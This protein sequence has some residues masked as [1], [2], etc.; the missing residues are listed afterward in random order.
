MNHGISIGSIFS[1][2][3]GLE[4]GLELANLGVTEWQ[5]E[6]EKY[7]REVLRRHWPK[8][9]QFV[10]VREVGRKNLS[11]V[12]I[13]CGGF[14]CQ[15]FSSSGKR[16]GFCDPRSALWAEQV[17]IIREMSPGAV[18]VENVAEM[19][20]VQGEQRVANDLRKL[21]YIV[22]RPVII[23]AATL[24]APHA[25]LRVFMLAFKP[26]HAITVGPEPKAFSFDYP[27]FRGQAPKPGE[28]PRTLKK[29]TRYPGTYKR[30]RLLA[31]GN[32]VMPAMGYVVGL[33]LRDLLHPRG[34]VTEMALDRMAAEIPPPKG[35]R[36]W[37]T[38][39]TTDAKGSRRE[40]ARKAHWKSKT[41]TS[42][43]DAVWL[44]DPLDYDRPLNPD[45][46]EGLMSFPRGFTLPA[47]AVDDEED[48]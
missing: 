16:A 10:D 13:L 9:H 26:A 27:A 19:L 23:N 37:P 39:V 35:Y 18:V 41:G 20:L 6:L 46:V 38:P 1:G 33:R 24:G 48:D 8:A 3:G 21:G 30:A 25:R 12:S 32:A 2:V 14:P 42:L 17:R 4:L 47:S 15:G 36:Y 44:S 43:T 31:L 29:A 28:A 7:P 5:V 22:D 40:T 11:P 45:W 34:R